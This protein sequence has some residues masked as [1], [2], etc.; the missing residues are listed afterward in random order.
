MAD[1]QGVHPETGQFPAVRH[2]KQQFPK[3]GTYAA[4][5]DD[6]GP[7]PDIYNDAK[8]EY[9][10]MARTIVYNQIKETFGSSGV[11]FVPEDVYLVWFCY[12]LGG[13]KALCSTTL[14]DGKYYEVTHSPDG[15]TFVDT[16]VKI[17]NR[18]V[19]DTPQEVFAKAHQSMTSYNPDRSNQHTTGP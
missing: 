12:I 18:Q 10:D 2:P 13:W 16:Y 7:L 5:L 14:P 17:W 9:P 8:L 1:N 11:T 15:R 6:P 3:L 19:Q 4:P